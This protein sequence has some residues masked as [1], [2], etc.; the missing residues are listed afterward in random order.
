MTEKAKFLNYRKADAIAKKYSTPCYVYDEKLLEKQARTALK[1]PNAFG[2]TVRYAMKAASNAAILKLFN[3]LG[4]HMDAS[5]A[6]EAE[7]AMLAGIPPEKISLSSQELPS[8]LKDILSKGVKYNA[9]SL[10][11][12]EEF[13]KLFPKGEV[14]VRVNPGLG[15]GG[16]NR[17]NV[18]GPASSFGIWHEYFGEIDKIAK[19]YSLKIIRIHTHIGSGSDPKVW[20][21]VA[22]M[23]L[24]T[25]AYFKE[26]KT[27]NMG[28]GFKV[29]RVA[30]EKSTDMQKIG[31]PI[32]ELV[33][34][35]AKKSGRKLFFEIEPGTFLTANSAVVLAKV[36]DICDTGKT[37]YK[38]I[39]L[40]TGMTDILRPSIYGAQHPIAILPKKPSRKIESFVI[41]G[42][43]C[44]SGDIL[45]PAVGDP[46]GILPRKLQK[47]EIGDYCEIGGAGAYC[48]AMCTL[49]YNSYP[50]AAEVILKKNGSVKLMRK[51]QTLAQIIEN[52]V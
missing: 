36:Q 23:S 26:V 29:A 1:F 37:G 25:V 35:F 4:L 45:T 18:G 43:C 11:Q 47:P 33:K 5:S 42:H 2:L 28:G 38:F 10:R 31:K 27:L 40:D 52:E 21:K 14:G 12:L 32:A 50:A 16:T 48:S 34:N 46:E 30:G 49:N 6:Y 19:K 7:R 17:T 22:K 51:R 39:K 44:E 9:C 8:N 15:S 41:A 13:G 3:S 20:Q 24:N